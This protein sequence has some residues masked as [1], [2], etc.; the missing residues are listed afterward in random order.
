M[1]NTKLIDTI[2]NGL[3]VSCQ[4]RK[5]WPMYGATIMSAFSKAAEQGGAVGIRATEPENIKAIKNTTNLPIIGI[6]KQWTDGYDIYITPSYSSAKSIIEAGASIVALDGT[7]RERPNGETLEEII[8]K[9]NDKYPE[10]LI[11]ADCATFED[12]VNAEKL[13]A[14]IISTTLRGYTKETQHIKSVDYDLI[15]KFANE[16]NTPVVA[17]GKIHTPEQAKKALE[18][19]A[20]AVVV[21][22]AITRPE[23]ITKW[24]VEEIKTLG[25]Q[26]KSM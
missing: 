13:G 3:I 16:L 17:E 8:K 23:I 22:T 26:V 12:G 19:G 4:A 24:F 25:K 14:D 6:N 9:I 18:Y 15:R 10:I 20:H 11:M 21:G 1:K 7:Q 5:G 2:K